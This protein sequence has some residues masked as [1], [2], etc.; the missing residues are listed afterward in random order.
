MLKPPRSLAL[1]VVFIP[2]AVLGLVLMFA[3]FGAAIEGRKTPVGGAS[4]ALDFAKQDLDLVGGRWI[5]RRDGRLAG[6]AARN[7][8]LWLIGQDGSQTLV[9]GPAPALARRLIGLDAAGPGTSG[10]QSGAPAAGDLGALLSEAVVERHARGSRSILLAVGGVDQTT[11]T[12][13]DVLHTYSPLHLV[14]LVVALSALGA[15]AL[16]LAVPLLNRAIRPIVAEASSIHPDDTGRRL[17]EACAPRELLPLARAFNGALD[18]L[19]LELGR[20]KRL[21]SN[22]AHEL[23]TPLAVLSLRVDSLTVPEPQREDLRAEVE[24]LA[25]LAQQMLDLERLSLPE[26]KRVAVDLTEVAQAVVSALAPMAID[27][28][29]DLSLDAPF[30]PVMVL[31]DPQAVERAVLNLVQNAVAHGGGRGAIRVTVGLG[32]LEVTDEGP[33]VPEELQPRLFDAFARG[34]G[35]SDGSGLGL[36]LTRE[37][38]RGL[39]GEVG[40]FRHARRTTF[41]LRFPQRDLAGAEG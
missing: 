34:P 3:L 19:E 30:G 6:L 17:D 23:R 1:R 15:V 28:G 35:P 2:L 11:I 16:L 32:R 12:A 31:G 5:L 22:V 4:L 33:G 40:W 20:R 25:R 38:M 9:I 21:I 10:E 7:P 36:H 39:G 41:E 14:F 29:Y 37:I 13:L 27:A 8:S 18:R 26:G 24:R